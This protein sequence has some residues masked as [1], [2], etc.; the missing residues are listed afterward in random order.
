MWRQYLGS[1]VSVDDPAAGDVHDD[2]VGVDVVAPGAVGQHDAGAVVGR[3]VFIPELNIF[4][5]LLKFSEDLFC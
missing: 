4:F 1:D 3:D 5:H 2:V